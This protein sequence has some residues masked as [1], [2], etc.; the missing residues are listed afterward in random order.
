[1]LFRSE[2]GQ[3]IHITG[4]SITEALNEG[5]RRGYEKGFL[6]KSVVGDPFSREN[7]RDNTPAIIHYDLVP[8]DR[9][10]VTLAPKG[11]GSENM[12]ALR[13]LKPS[14]GL[15]GMMDFVVE[16]VDKAGANPCP[17]IVVGV[18]V[19]GTMEKAAFLAKKALLRDI[20]T[21]DRKSVV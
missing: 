7:T 17:P 11:F 5:V 2:V 18:G 13:M 14:D 20:G 3:D 9:L 21:V 4:G 6:R 15:A 12:G 19:G 16:T 1:M 10:T 8:G